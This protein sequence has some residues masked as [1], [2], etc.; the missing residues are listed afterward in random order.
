MSAFYE[1]KTSV[2]PPDYA[3]YIPVAVPIVL[4][5]VTLAIA[6]AA[7]SFRCLLGA[8]CAAITSSSER[9]EAACEAEKVPSTR[10][11]GSGTNARAGCQLV[12]I[13][14]SFELAN[15]SQ[16]TA[17]KQQLVESAMWREAQECAAKSS[18]CVAETCY[19]NYLARLGPSTFHKPAAQALQGAFERKCGA[20]LL[21]SSADGRYLA[22]SSQACGM[23]PQSVAIEIN[24]GRISWRH[25]FGGISFQWSGWVN[26]SGAIEAY[27][28]NGSGFRA[29][30]QFDDFGRQVTM[31]YP[32]CDDSIPM[33]I[34][35]KVAN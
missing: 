35:N 31:T 17:I 18:A 3:A 6:A 34:I 33:H 15:D 28:L 1:R 4:G 27:V 22:R 9:R 8:S 21:P 23:T 30:G 20:A 29:A 13:A 26:S 2:R 7:P 32:S 25:E 5:F 24:H 16:A 14:D 11:I 10:K 12:S 19:S